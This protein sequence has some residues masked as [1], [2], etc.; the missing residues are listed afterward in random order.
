MNNKRPKE[1]HE[2]NNNGF[3]DYFHAIFFS[4]NIIFDQI[5]LYRIKNLKD[6]RGIMRI[7]GK[8]HDLNK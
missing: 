2:L 4:L 5:H 1:L 6:I 7:S 8:L 3:Y